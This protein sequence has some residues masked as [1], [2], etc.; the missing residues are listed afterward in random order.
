[1]AIKN[2][3]QSNLPDGLIT[4]L[5]SVNLSIDEELF[6]AENNFHR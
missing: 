2:M 1:M 5:N 4:R 6:K 3:K